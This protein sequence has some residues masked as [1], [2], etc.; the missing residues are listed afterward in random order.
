MGVNVWLLGPFLQR[1]CCVKLLTTVCL[2]SL[3]SPGFPKTTLLAACW[4]VSTSP[5]AWP[6]TR[7][8]NRY[9]V[10]C[11]G[12][13]I[14]YTY[15]NAKSQSTS[16]CMEAWS[17]PCQSSIERLWCLSVEV[18]FNFPPT[19]VTHVTFYFPESQPPSVYLYAHKTI[20]FRVLYSSITK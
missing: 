4:A 15:V 2:S 20:R 6:R 3:Q 16:V 8:G 12:Y 17:N 19:H 10:L 9:V 13:H 7:S 14:Y 5:T 1:W 18:Y 11:W